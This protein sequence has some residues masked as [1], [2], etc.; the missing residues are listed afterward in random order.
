MAARAITRLGHAGTVAAEMIT[1]FG[2]SYAVGQPL[3]LIVTRIVF[4]LA[5]TRSEAKRLGERAGCR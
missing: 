5:R 1:T 3:L 2:V 4:N